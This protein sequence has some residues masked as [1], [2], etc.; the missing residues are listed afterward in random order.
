MGAAAFS[1]ANALLQQH[2]HLHRDLSEERKIKNKI[3]NS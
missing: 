2:Q 3:P 1:A